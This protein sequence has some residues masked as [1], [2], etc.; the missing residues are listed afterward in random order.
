MNASAFPAPRVAPNSL[1]A[2]GGMWRLASRRYRTPGF[3]LKLLV[4]LA[5]LTLS[6][7]M[8]APNPG[9]PKGAFLGWAGAFYLPIIVP[10]LSFI[11]S[12][13]ATRDDLSP[14]SVDY[15]LTRPVPRPLQ[16]LFRYITQMM[17]AQL[18]FLFPFGVIV[19]VGI[20]HDT[21]N[22]EEFLPTLLLAQIVAI[23]VYSAAGVLCAQLSRWYIILGLVYGAMIEIGVGV[24][25]T[26]LGQISL[27]R[28]VLSITAPIVGERDPL[29][30]SVARDPT[31]LP[32]ALVILLCFIVAALAVSATLFSRKEFSG[33]AGKES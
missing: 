26:Q 15:V 18:D 10:L 29:T 19:A 16:V 9:Q 22:L 1:H 23:A 13:S 31:A 30:A 3:W 11:F 4:G 14:A 27:L 7:I 24:V 2:F 8:A 21:Q 33:A 20:Y 17:C 12:G 5:L 25:P 28:H 32:V 6:S